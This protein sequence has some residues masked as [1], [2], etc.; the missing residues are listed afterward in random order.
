MAEA[1]QQNVLRKATVADSRDPEDTARL[2][3]SNPVATFAYYYQIRSNLSHRGKAAWRDF[4][5]VNDA[6]S[7]LLNITRTYLE[8]L[9]REDPSRA[10]NATQQH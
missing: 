6:L 4:A 5:T 10:N 1:V 8:H 9:Q 3:A 7:E 2:D